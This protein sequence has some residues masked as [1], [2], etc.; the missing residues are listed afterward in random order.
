[1]PARLGAAAGSARLPAYLPLVLLILRMHQ[2]HALKLPYRAGEQVPAT[3]KQRL[4]S[5][6]PM[7]LIGNNG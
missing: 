2:E 7:P 3:V 1:M 6:S 5:G 4:G